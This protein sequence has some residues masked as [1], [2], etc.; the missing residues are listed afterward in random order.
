MVTSIQNRL[1][2][3]M[4]AAKQ[5]NKVDVPNPAAALGNGNPWK[6]ERV[7]METTIKRKVNLEGFGVVEGVFVRDERG[8]FC[9]EANG[10]PWDFR[11]WGAPDAMDTPEEAAEYLLMLDVDDP[12]ES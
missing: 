5:I 3:G 10:V 9:R 2:L 4:M 6:L 8:W 7:T 11:N 1:I 12:A